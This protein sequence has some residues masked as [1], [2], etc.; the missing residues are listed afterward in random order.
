MTIAPSSTRFRRARG[1]R[2][3]SSLCKLNEIQFERALDAAPRA[4]ARG[5]DPGARRSI[6][7]GR[8]DRHAP[9]QTACLA[10]RAGA[11]RLRDGAAE[12]AP[13][14]PPRRAD[15][16]ARSARAAAAAAD[17][18]RSIMARTALQVADLWLPD[19]PGPHP[20]VLM[21]H[22]GC[23]QTEIA[24]RR[25]MNWIADDLRRRGIAVWNIDY[26][27][28]DRPGGGYPGTFQDAAAAADALRAHAGRIPSRSLAAWSR[29]ATAPA[30]ISR[31]G[32]PA[33]PRLPRE[34]AAAQPRDPLADPRR[35]SASAACPTSRKRR[36]RRTA[37]ATR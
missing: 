32:W 18:D 28:V 30:A 22:G 12:P 13:A 15:G 25:I 1:R 26:R 35:R 7:A 4:A 17:R 5:F 9:R 37:A 11:S 10:P 20:T 36:A 23:W 3:C 24:D 21:V 29:S 34:L 8:G 33:R 31:S 16:L 2:S 14:A 19:G 6:A 27:G